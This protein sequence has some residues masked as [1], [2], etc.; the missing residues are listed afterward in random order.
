MTSSTDNTTPPA[1]SAAFGAGC[2]GVV[3]LGHMGQAF[4][5]NLVEDGH[6]VLVYDRDPARIAALV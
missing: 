1:G 6:R 5:A 3:G 2:L 4:A